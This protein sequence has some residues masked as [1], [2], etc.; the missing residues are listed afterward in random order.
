MRRI[1]IGLGLA[2][3]GL[4]AAC[5]TGPET[6]VTRFYL[7]PEIAR[8]QITVE[9]ISPADKGG[10]EFQVYADAVGKELARLGFTEA[11]GLSASEQVAVVGVE[12]GTRDGPARRSGLSIGIG[13]GSYGPGGGFGG[14]V[15]VPVGGS[16]P[17]PIVV[18]RM[19]VQIKRR[20]DASVIWEGRGEIAALRSSPAAV[21]QRL[22][23]ALF[24]DFPGVSGRTIT[25]R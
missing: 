25:V 10:L 22:A 8:G 7:D 5:A 21:A 3:L 23:A 24:K 9:P 15:T 20:S 16:R 12:R 14:G 2:A 18:T 13:G 6:H 1:G 4:L 17:N 19:I 11:P